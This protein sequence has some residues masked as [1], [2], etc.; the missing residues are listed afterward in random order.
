MSWAMGI[1]FV[2]VASALS[3]TLSRPGKSE[4]S[5]SIRFLGCLAFIPYFAWQSLRGG[6]DVAKY[7]LHSNK[8]VNGGFYRHQTTLPRGLARLVFIQV[9]SLL[10]GTVSAGQRDDE[11][12]VHVLDVEALEVDDIRECERR[13][14][15]LFSLPE[16]V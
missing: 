11:I 7:A 8:S 2:F 15:L 12:L 14:S 4:A 9:L 3:V 16:P 6:W 13:V 10:P 1:F 5:P